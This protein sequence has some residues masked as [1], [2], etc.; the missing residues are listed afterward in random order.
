MKILTFILG[1]MQ[2]NCYFLIDEETGETAVVD[3]AASADK[4]AEKIKE[5]GLTLKYIVLTHAHFDHIMA[6]EELRGLTHAPVYIHADDAEALLHPEQ[7]YMDQFGGVNTPC[8]PAD[9]LLNDGDILILGQTKIKIIHTPGHT[10]G[11]I[12]LIADENIISGD[13]LFRGDIGRYDL[14]G[15]DYSQLLQ[16]LR[17]LAALD[18]DY[19]V[20]PGH[21]SSTRLSYERE[22][23]IYLS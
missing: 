8:S 15:G 16:S 10:M 12:C 17:I 5:R 18:G 6:L 14:Y 9:F 22:H 21:G 3:P 20:Y 23:N 19:K 4:I 1:V 2:T 11:S 7:T 13:T